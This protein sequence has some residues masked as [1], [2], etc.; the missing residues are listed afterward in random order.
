MTQTPNYGAIALSY[1]AR[2]WRVHPLRAGGKIPATKHGC[3]D[4]TTDPEQIRRWWSMWP[5]A[6]IGL[7]TGYQFW[8]LDID[9]D[10]LAWAESNDLPATIE[11]TTGRGGRH[12]LYRLPDGAV[13]RN[14]AGAIARGVDVRGMGG[15]IVAAPSVHPSG[16]RYTWLDCDG[17]V[18]D[19]EPADA[20]AWLLDMVTRGAE[21]GQGEAFRLPEVVAEGG[22]D[23]TMYKLACSL[24]AQ[25]FGAAEIRAALA[26]ANARCSPPLPDADLDRIAGSAAKHAPGRSP[27]FEARRAEGRGWAASAAEVPDSGGWASG[28]RR[29]GTDYRP[30]SSTST[31]DSR[32]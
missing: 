31:A 20:P 5:E 19:G 14:S 3:K 26:A 6:N 15:Y 17:E 28:D 16:T 25:G 21:T 27:E 22:R 2:G 1:A 13:V 30:S 4:A 7:A 9:P 29:R 18:P 32:C 12:M 10:G 8:V 11:A 23:N 24:R